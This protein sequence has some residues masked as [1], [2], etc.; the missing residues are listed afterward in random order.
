MTPFT[1]AT[2][3]TDAAGIP[4]KYWLQFLKSFTDGAPDERIATALNAIAGEAKK[5]VGLS[6]E[7][8]RRAGCHAMGWSETSAS[9]DHYLRRRTQQ[10]ATQASVRIQQTLMG[11]VPGGA[12]DA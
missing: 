5:S 7:S 9:A 2:L 6:A 12:G 4:L 11:D 8:E 1:S 3:E 10:A